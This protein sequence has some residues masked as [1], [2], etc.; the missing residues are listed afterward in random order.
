MK[1]NLY[2][3]L[4]FLKCKAIDPQI[5]SEH[6]KK[7]QPS[8]AVDKNHDSEYASK[9]NIT[10]LFNAFIDQE[11]SKEPSSIYYELN[12]ESK[13]RAFAFG[14]KIGEERAE[15]NFE[16]KLASSYK[17]GLQD[18]KY[19]DQQTLAEDDENAAAR[20][21]PA[22]KLGAEFATK[23]IQSKIEQIEEENHLLKLKKNSID[24]EIQE[25]DIALE[26]KDAEIE[27][28]D[29]EIERMDAE[30]ENK[31]AK[32]QALRK[33]NKFIVNWANSLTDEQITK[34]G[35]KDEDLKKLRKEP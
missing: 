21:A 16:A 14:F 4:L 35:L 31:E 7:N 2:C 12:K 8:T 1:K 32:Y 13:A 3:F 9:N 25:K 34:I 11:K 18:G 24:K 26:G 10:S 28:M 15:R 22:C 33:Q 19:A 6:Q 30:I 5:E 20:N 29:A 17:A 23:K 27:R